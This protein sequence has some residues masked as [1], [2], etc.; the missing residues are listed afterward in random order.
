[1]RPSGSHS[2]LA[3]RATV[4]AVVDHQFIPFLEDVKGQHHAGE[5]NG[6]HRKKWQ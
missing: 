5:K 3:I 1:M 4:P 2:Q 6:I